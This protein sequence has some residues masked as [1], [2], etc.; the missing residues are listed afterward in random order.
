MKVC[1]TSAPT[2]RTKDGVASLLDLVRSSLRLRPDRISI[3]EVR[4]AEA[5]DLLKAW[6][7]IHPGSAIGALRRFEQ[8]IQE[9]FVT[10]PRAL[11][12]ETINLVTV[13]R[14]CGSVRRLKELAEINGLN[15]DGD[16]HVI[17]ASLSAGDLP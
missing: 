14:G 13:L 1:P 16:Y 11:I 12:A 7:T 8:L 4:G 15:S 2:E 10:V 3:G 9:D 6:G 5:L 17:A